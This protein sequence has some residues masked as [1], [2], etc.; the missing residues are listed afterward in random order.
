MKL[1]AL[2][3]AA[4]LVIATSACGG[5]HGPAVPDVRGKN[6]PDAA[7]ALYGAHLCVRAIRGRSLPWGTPRLPVVAQSPSPGT[8]R[9]EWSLVTLTVRFPEPPQARVGRSS[10]LDVIW[11]GS[12][13]PCPPIQSK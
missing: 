12:K 2:L 1:V 11:G 6:L 8:H 3:A 5:A 7:V 10:G 4:S 13:P 9:R